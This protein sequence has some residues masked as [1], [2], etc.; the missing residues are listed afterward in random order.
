MI[1]REE[2]SNR[3]R[4]SL[5][6]LNRFKVYNRTGV[7][8]FNYYNLLGEQGRT[9][10]RTSLRGAGGS[11]WSPTDYRPIVEY[12]NACMFQENSHLDYAFIVEGESDCW[13]LNQ[14]SL[15]GIGIP[16][17]ENV[18]CLIGSRLNKFSTLY[19][20]QENNNNSQTYPG[21]T[22]KFIHDLVK[23]LKTQGTKIRFR[24]RSFQMNLK[25]SAIFIWSAVISVQ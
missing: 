19:L 10:T 14:H 9:R 5:D 20:V 8:E 11:N 7:V 3:K 1:Q 23:V 17:A 2:L 16:G 4:V 21:G 12:A 15:L 13:V 25:I 18:E 22:G 24:L 6:V